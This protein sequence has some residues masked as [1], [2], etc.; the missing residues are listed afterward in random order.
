[1][2]HL[3]F[4][5]QSAQGTKVAVD[6]LTLN[7]VEGQITSLLGHNGAGKTTTMSM[8]TGLYNPTGG[9]AYINGKSVLTQMD[10]IRTD[11]GLCPQHNV[12]WDKLTVKE[13]L[14]LFG[15]LK[16]CSVSFM[17]SWLSHTNRISLINWHVVLNVL[18]PASH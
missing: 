18:M 16:V 6:G 14:E 13:H 5:A 8:L 1:M 15:T 3:N 12:L 10:D 11:L 4:P 7:L 9:N 17:S 2:S